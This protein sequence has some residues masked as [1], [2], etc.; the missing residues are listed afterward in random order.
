MGARKLSKQGRAMEQSPQ[1]SRPA[2]SPT[3]PQPRQ[4]VAQAGSMPAG[5]V[6]YF[7]ST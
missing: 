2:G 3:A 6:V 7:Y 1:G 5:P 4:Q